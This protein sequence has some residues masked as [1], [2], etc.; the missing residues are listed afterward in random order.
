MGY[1]D[2]LKDLDLT[3]IGKSQ[4]RMPYKIPEVRKPDPTARTVDRAIANYK[5]LSQTSWYRSTKKSAELINP[6]LLEKTVTTQRQKH[7]KQL[8][9]PGFVCGDF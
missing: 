6:E 4:I 9:V 3:D 7:V 5:P 1:E 2:I 8:L